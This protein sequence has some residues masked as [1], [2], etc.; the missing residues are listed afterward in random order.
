MM[1]R[2][3]ASSRALLRNLLPRYETGLLQA[4]TSFRPVEIAGR[5]TSWR[6]D[7]TRLHVDSFSSSPVQGKAARVR[8][9]KSARSDPHL[10][11]R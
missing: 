5:P 4:R 2:F 9:R 7:D 1:Q 8:Q 3:A 11:A 10:E 6:K